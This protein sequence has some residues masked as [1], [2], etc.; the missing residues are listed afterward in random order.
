MVAGIGED[1]ASRLP[2]W[3]GMEEGEGRELGQSVSIEEREGTGRVYG[4]KT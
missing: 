2:G 1:M 4:P 3:D